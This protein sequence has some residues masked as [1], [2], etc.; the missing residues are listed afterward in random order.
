MTLEKTLGFFTVAWATAALIER[1]GFQWKPDS[2]RLKVAA[3]FLLMF[4]N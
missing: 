1:F 3:N 2:P 4:T